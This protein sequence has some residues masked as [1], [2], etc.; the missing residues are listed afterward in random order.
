VQLLNDTNED[1]DV[2]ARA[3]LKKQNELLQQLLKDPDESDRAGSS[4]NSQV[5]TFKTPYCCLLAS[6][7][8]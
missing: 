1:P 6:M 8:F 2:E 4:A 5:S 7:R 3:G